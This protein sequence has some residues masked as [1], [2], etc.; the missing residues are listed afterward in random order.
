M[1]K[2]T[3]IIIITS[4]EDIIQRFISNETENTR[5]INLDD[6]KLINS[7]ENL[8]HSSN[9]KSNNDNQ[10]NKRALESN[11]NN[12]GK[13][14]KVRKKWIDTVCAICGNQGMGYNYN[15]LT[16]ASCKTFFRRNLNEDVDKLQCLTGQGQCSI[17]HEI[18][19]KCQKCRL[20]RCFS[21]G[22]KHNFVKNNKKTQDIE[23][24]LNISLVASFNEIDQLLMNE[25]NIIDSKII[26]DTLFSQLSV[27]DWITIQNIQSSFKFFC[28]I[29]LEENSS[30]MDL[31]DHTSALISWSYVG[32]KNAMCFINFFRHMKQFEELNN[33][34]RFILIKYNLFS[35][36]L[37]SKGYYYKRTS[38]N[39]SAKVWQKEDENN[40]R[41]LSLCD[42]SSYDLNKFEDLTKCLIELT[43]RD[44]II[45]SLLSTILMFSPGISMNENEPLLKDSLTINRIQCYF[46]K[47]LW[48]YLLDKLDELQAY[49]YFI[50][51]FILILKIQLRTKELRQFFQHQYSI[52]NTKDKVAPL[53][54]T[55]LHF[56]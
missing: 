36:F 53:M 4:D 29:P 41:F 44:P 10:V 28:E 15:V 51:L 13:S 39:Y 45:I 55:I 24:N 25:N 27:E 1:N 52:T 23:E 31:S 32:S 43:E 19:R 2:N 33:D 26:S 56:P 7:T 30:L 9:V 6:K 54:Q 21:M 11:I 18:R 42:S 38:C 14:I 46:T 12:E 48:N 49:K 20:K 16:C 22:M 17:S 3:K 5:I 34:D 37:S 40:R 47:I 35:I 50:Q 8:H